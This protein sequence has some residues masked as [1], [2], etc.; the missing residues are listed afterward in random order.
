MKLFFRTGMPKK[1]GWYLVRLIPGHVNGNQKYDV[2]YCRATSDG[3]RE[4]VKWYEHNVSHYAA[5]D[6]QQ[7]IRVESEC[8]A[9][10]TCKSA[11]TEKA[12]MQMI[13]G[14]PGKEVTLDFY[15]AMI[16]RI[17]S[18]T[19]RDGKVIVQA[20]IDDEY[21]DCGSNIVPA[22]KGN[23]VIVRED[24]ITEYQD[25]EPMLTALTATPLKEDGLSPLKIM[26]ET[27]QNEGNDPCDSCA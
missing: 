22:F 12:T 5:L 13:K 15:G 23:K 11:F 25:V 4:W 1:D 19:V 21:L 3:G 16:G 26:Q 27:V 6:E 20:D 18:A 8:F 17:V 24:G 2:D 10:E 14:L 9:I 7:Y